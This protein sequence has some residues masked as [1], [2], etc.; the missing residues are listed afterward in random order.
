MLGMCVNEDLM[1]T[2]LFSG[3]VRF[4]I[5]LEMSTY[6]TNEESPYVLTAALDKFQVLFDIYK[7]DTLFGNIRVIRARCYIQVI[8]Q[9]LFRRH[10]PFGL[11]LTKSQS[12]F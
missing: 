9:I 12:N 11:S 2:C 3:H 8:S 6:L 4:D 5:P 7:L 10:W 1:G